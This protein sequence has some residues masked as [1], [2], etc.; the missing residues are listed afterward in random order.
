MK[1]K[2]LIL[3]ALTT[4]AISCKTIKESKKE[5]IVEVTALP[6]VTVGGGELTEAPVITRYQ[7]S[8][9]R[10]N[11]LIHTKLEVKFDWEK[12]HL[13][14]KAELIFRPYFYSTKELI[15]DAKGID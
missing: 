3:L 15:L 14:G 2:L 4:F 6:E 12:Q 10:L 1:K 5:E 11:D 8:N 9:T 7:A 13:L